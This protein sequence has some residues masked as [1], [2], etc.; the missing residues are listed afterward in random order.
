[1]MTPSSVVSARALDGLDAGGDHVG[2]AP[3]VGPAEALKGGA[4]CERG[5]FEGR[6]A[7][8]EVTKERRIFLLKPL[9]DV[10][11]GVF[12]GTGQAVGE[13]DV[14]AD[15]SLTVFDALRQ[16]AHGGALGAEGGQLVTVFEEQFDLECG[17][18][19]VIFGPARGTRFAVLGHGEGID[20]KEHE[21]LILAQRRHDGPF[22]AFQAHGKRR[23]VEPRTQALDP[24]VDHLRSVVEAQQ[25]PVRRAAGLSTDI[26]FGIRPVEAD[27]RRKC[28][29]RYALH[30]S[31]RR[32]W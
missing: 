10:W 7:A 12:E 28:L 23:T 27:T 21:E 15:Q 30:V 6:P 8:Q 29:C 3:V 16:G 32:V 31:P 22:L 13:T 25:L 4:T 11:E 19:R 17:V 1:V 18:G 26:V 5:G 24:R 14:V 2:R 9:Q 20:G